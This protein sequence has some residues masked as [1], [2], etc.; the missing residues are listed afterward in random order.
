[1]RGER[2]SRLQ[3]LSVH[4]SDKH[5]MEIPVP[6]KGKPIPPKF[7]LRPLTTLSCAELQ[8]ATTML[9]YAFDEHPLFRLA[10]PKAASRSMILRPLF[11]TVLKDAIRFGRVDVACSHKIVG[12]LI[13]YPPG[14]YPMSK[15]RILRLLPHYA[16]LVAVGPLGL[17]KLFRA[18]TTLNVLRPK[19]P[20]CHGYF[21]GGRQGERVGTVL[22]KCLL[23]EADDKGWPIYLETQERRSANLYARLG[24]KMLQAPRED[25]RLGRLSSPNAPNAAA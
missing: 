15:F 19:E 9:A 23:N 14:C 1:M 18:Q 3:S 11:A 20:H 22:A 8:E 25:V 2:K 17:M 16:R 24:F 13:W 12:M 21:L 5:Q 10:F 7:E 4:L 6:P